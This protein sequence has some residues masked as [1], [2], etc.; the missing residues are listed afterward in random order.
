MADVTALA[1]IISRHLAVERYS[2]TVRPAQHPFDAGWRRLPWIIIAQ[3]VGGPFLVQTRTQRHRVVDGGGTVLPE[4]CLAWVTGNGLAAMGMAWGLFRFRAW[5]VVD[6]LSLLR[7]PLAHPPAIGAR[8]GE[9]CAALWSLD[10]LPMPPHLR[11]ARRQELLHRLLVVL[12]EAS[13]PEPMAPERFVALRRL[14]PLFAEIDS[15]LA[16]PWPRG[17]VARRLGISEARTSALF[18]QAV[19]CGPVAWIHR[20]RMQEAQRLLASTATPVAEIGS[21]VG[22]SDPS[23]FS[24]RFRA[25]VGRSPQAWR[26][27]LHAR[28]GDEI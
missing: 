26:A 25:V 27:D 2:G 24:R 21:V 28:L 6:L 15:R 5:G 3:A 14:Q 11:C 8:L 7:M 22:I 18:Q 20:R 13:D 4:D 23:Q 17:R 12:L 10:R 16:E 9:A 1:E 19:G